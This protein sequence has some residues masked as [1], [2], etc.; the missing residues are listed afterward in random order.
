MNKDQ[1]FEVVELGVAS[2]E[3]K[4]PVGGNSESAGHLIPTGISDAD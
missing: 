3:T 2:V 4:G 1:E